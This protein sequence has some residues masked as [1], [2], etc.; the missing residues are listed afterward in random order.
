MRVFQVFFGRT[1]QGR[2][3]LSESEWDKFRDDVITPNLPNGYTVL[4]GTGAWLSAK[5]HTTITEPTKILIAAMA[6]APASSA[7]IERLRQAYATEFNQ[8]SVGMT[9]YLACGSF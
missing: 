2:G 1:I 5:T 7:A 9:T 4:D 3:A 8:E 6:D